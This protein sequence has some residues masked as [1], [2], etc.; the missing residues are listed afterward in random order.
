MGIYRTVHETMLFQLSY[1]YLIPQEA[2]EGNK[3]DEERKKKKTK[4]KTDQLSCDFLL[5]K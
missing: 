2:K 1:V 5:L 3:E 4:T